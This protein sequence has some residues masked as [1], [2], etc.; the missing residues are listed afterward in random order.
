MATTKLGK[1]L[2][3]I[4]ID[5]DINRNQ[6]AKEIGVSNNHLANV[7]LGK[8]EINPEALQSICD[9]YIKDDPALIV[10]LSKA[11]RDS[12]EFVTFDMKALTEQQKELVFKVRGQIHCDNTP[13]AQ[14][15]DDSKSDDVAGDIAEELALDSSG[16][17]KAA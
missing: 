13:P 1:E 11:A 15:Y 4:R 3:K 5:F 10:K 9:T 8:E 6:M 16:H 17:K 2:K 12:I 14:P 7:E